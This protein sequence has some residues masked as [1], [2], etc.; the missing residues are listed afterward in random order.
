MHLASLPHGA[1]RASTNL[2]ALPGSLD[3]SSTMTAAT[4]QTVQYLNLAYFGRPADP[5]SLIGF[6]AT[7]M[8]D[9]E[10]VLAFVGTSEYEANTV[11]PNSTLSTSGSR[12]F[13]VTNLINTFYKRLFGRYAASSEISGWTNALTSG[14]V[15]YDY[16][17]ITIL[18][19]ALNLPKGTEMRETLIAKYDSAAAFTSAL[20]ADSAANA[21]YSTTKDDCF[22][23]CTTCEGN[24]C[25]FWCWV[26]SV[27]SIRVGCLESTR[28][29]ARIGYICCT[30]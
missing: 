27:C 29:T 3:F 13:N 19:A 10:I 6:P 22:V 5:A 17:G 9:E 18:R 2:V 30:V 16:L 4:A 15:N 7:G 12:T 21:A 25:H 24:Q 8:T 20:D 14:A 28:T 11:S 23:I 1:G 26:V